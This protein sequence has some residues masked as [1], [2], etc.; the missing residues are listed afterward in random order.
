V[1]RDKNNKTHA[2]Y[3]LAI[4]NQHNGLKVVLRGHLGI[5]LAAERSWFGSGPATMG[6]KERLLEVA[7]GRLH[8]DSEVEPEAPTEYSEDELD[9]DDDCDDDLDV[10]HSG[11]AMHV[12]GAGSGAAISSPARPLG[13]I[14]VPLGKAGLKCHVRSFYV[15]SCFAW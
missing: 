9:H 10:N 13:R 7:L 12:E 15:L 11:K 8:D 2:A 6:R 1:T 14:S 3:L 5:V 4:D